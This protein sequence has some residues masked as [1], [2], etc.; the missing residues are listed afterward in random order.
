MV[1]MGTA[2]LRAALRLMLRRGAALRKPRPVVCSGTR[3][4]LRLEVIPPLA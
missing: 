4:K 2:Y 1:G 3:R